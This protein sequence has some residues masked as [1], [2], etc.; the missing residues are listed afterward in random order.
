MQCGRETMRNGNQGAFLGR[1]Q[2]TPMFTGMFRHRWTPSVAEGAEEWERGS[3]RSRRVRLKADTTRTGPPEGGHYVDWSARRRTL[4]G[5]V[6]L[7]PGH[8]ERRRVFAT[9]LRS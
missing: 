5:Q 3:R 9:T 2:Q 8:Y 6:R 1:R 4:P 7:K